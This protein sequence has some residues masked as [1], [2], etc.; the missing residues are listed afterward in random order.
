ML[1]PDP[2]VAGQ[3]DQA[4]VS[5]KASVATVIDPQR[6]GAVLVGEPEVLRRCVIGKGK[7]VF[8]NFRDWHG[9]DARRRHVDFQGG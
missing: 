3:E 1:P 8:E 7:P 9:I 2:L 5:T 4:V 6:H